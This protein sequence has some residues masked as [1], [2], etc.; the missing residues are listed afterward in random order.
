[1]TVRCLFFASLQVAVGAREVD[2]ELPEGS[3]LADLLATLEA[4]HPA[5]SAHRRSFRVALDGEFAEL[6]ARLSA[7]AEVALI[8]P[9]SG[10]GGG[11]VR[12]GSD[13]ISVDRCLEAVRRP[14]CGAVLL[15]LGTVRDHHLGQ[16]VSGLEYEAYER[17]AEPALR[18]L[19]AQV[20][21]RHPVGEVA[22]WHRFGRLEPGDISVAVAVSSAHREAA[23]QAGRW[24]IDT[25][26]ETVPLWKKEFA[27]DGVVWMEGDA[28]HPA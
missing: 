15:F 20:R 28:R 18:E 8:P 1:M 11:L 16:R 7:G 24:A 23:F 2:L 9:V 13:P 26:K 21:A 3:T 12:L 4:R 6:G 14:D 25:L 22:L 27:E 17:M 10:G 19:A 5:L